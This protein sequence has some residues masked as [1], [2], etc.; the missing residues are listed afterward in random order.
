M[1]CSPGFV[2]L[3]DFGYA[4]LPPDTAFE[5]PLIPMNLSGGHAGHHRLPDR[6]PRLA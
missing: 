4:T 2:P 1:F 6:P 3:T 5:P